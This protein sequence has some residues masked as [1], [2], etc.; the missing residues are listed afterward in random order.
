LLDIRTITGRDFRR[1]M[2]VNDSIAN[3]H[4]ADRHAS[5]QVGDDLGVAVEECLQVSYRFA[6]DRYDEDASPEE[7]RQ[8]VC[9]AMALGLLGG[10]RS[11]KL[12]GA[13]ES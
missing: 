1:A 3:E 12:L 4:G 8:L 13:E 2:D 5:L 11:I 10:L 9:M 6:Q 7:G